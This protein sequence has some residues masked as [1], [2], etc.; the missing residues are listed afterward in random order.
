MMSV[1]EETTTEELLEV[2]RKH[3]T[4]EIIVTKLK[5]EFIDGESFLDLCNNLMYM[6]MIPQYGLQFKF[7]KIYLKITG[8][9]LML[10]PMFFGLPGTTVQVS[11]A[12]TVGPA[13]SVSTATKDP[14][15]VEVS[16]DKNTDSTLSH[17]K[18]KTI[19]QREL[20]PNPAPLPIFSPLVQQRLD[21]VTG[22]VHSM[23]HKFIAELA[24]FYVCQG[25]YL[26]TQ[27]EYKN[28]GQTLQAKYSFISEGTPLTYFTKS[29]SAKVRNLRMHLKKKDG[30]SS[31]CN[32]TVA[33]PNKKPKVE[34]TPMPNQHEPTRETYNENLVETQI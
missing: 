16:V 6:Q 33:T 8:T 25:Y 31:S 4:P 13:P 1:T 5:D 34:S 23:W 12:T 30:D 32:R 17:M 26:R 3:G 9:N 10:P 11:N 22:S 14:A 24:E 29:L 21:A 7:R 15:S 18:S 20:V 27:V 2:L 19:G 28:I